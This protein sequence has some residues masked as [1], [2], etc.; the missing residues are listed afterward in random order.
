M[1]HLLP[2]IVT[3][4]F[5]GSALAQWA[6]ERM[7]ISLSPTPSADSFVKIAAV[8]GQFE[9]ASSKLAQQRADAES[10][11][12]AARMVSDHSKGAAAL[13][14]VAAAARIDVPKELDSSHQRKLDK[15][16][17]LHGADFDREY[18]SQQIA[19]HRD[20]VSLFERYAKGGDNKQLKSFAT[21]YLPHL[22]H[23]LQMA[24]KLQN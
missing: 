21:K 17:A 8:N 18:D 14:A 11:K 19:A 13:E 20:A 9:I 22:R 16:K 3:L 24:K 5:S 7:G 6:A 23:H 10:R 4:G 2:I 1:R 12:F 15:L